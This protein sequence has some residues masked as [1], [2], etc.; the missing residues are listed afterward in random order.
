MIRY[1]GG[2]EVPVD[3][4]V[5]ASGVYHDQDIALVLVEPGGYFDAGLERV[6]N[7]VHCWYGAPG[8]GR[9]GALGV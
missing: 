4:I 6:H 2:R 8:R 3:Q 1:E 7:G 9:R 5:G